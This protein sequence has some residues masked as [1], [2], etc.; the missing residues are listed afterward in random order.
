MPFGSAD[1]SIVGYAVQVTDLDPESSILLQSVG[2]GGK[3]H[4]GCGIFIDREAAVL[5]A[6]S[7]PKDNSLPKTLVRHTEDVIGA[8]D[9][10]FG[11][12]FGD[13][14]CEFFRVQDP[15]AFRLNLRISAT[16][17]DVGKADSGNQGM[18]RGQPEARVVRHEHLSTLLLLDRRVQAGIAEMEL[19]PPLSRVPS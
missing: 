18:L 13:R 6:K 9:A 17:H 5:L 8:A 14:W 2:L 11:G 16:L 15:Q 7:L 1:R 4:H 10:I 12:T 19:T 3:R